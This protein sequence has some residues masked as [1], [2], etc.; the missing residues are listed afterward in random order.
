MQPCLTTSAD[1]HGGEQRTFRKHPRIYKT[2]FLFFL[3]TVFLFFPLGQAD[4]E[5]HD[6]FKESAFEVK[7][8]IIPSCYLNTSGTFSFPDLDPSVTGD[9]NAGMGI[10]LMCTYGSNWTMSLDMGRWSNGGT[11]RMKHESKEYY[12]SYSL[13][14]DM[15]SGGGAGSKIL[16]PGASLSGTI[17]SLDYAGATP[18]NYSDTVIVTVTPSVAY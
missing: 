9:V 4:A 12:I 5:N 10:S 11:R 8:Y 7:T 15:A 14:T 18:G 13:R 1:F 2:F 6:V 17:K 3:V 16:I